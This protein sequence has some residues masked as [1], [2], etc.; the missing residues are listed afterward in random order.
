MHFPT[1]IK[2]PGH[3]L[4]FLSHQH[5]CRIYTDATRWW[6]AVIIRSKMSAQKRKICKVLYR[7]EYHLFGECVKHFYLYGGAAF[8]KNVKKAG[9]GQYFDVVLLT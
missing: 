2:R 8:G 3:W 1:E 9:L 7:Y 5:F 6:Q 4:P